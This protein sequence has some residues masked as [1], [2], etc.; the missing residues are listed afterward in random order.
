M[1]IRP[2]GGRR[3][4]LGVHGAARTAPG[5]ARSRTCPRTPL[6]TATFSKI[7]RRVQFFASARRRHRSDAR[8]DHAQHAHRRSLVSQRLRLVSSP[9]TAPRQNGLRRHSTPAFAS[10]LDRRTWVRGYAGSC[11]SYSP[12]RARQGQLHAA[13]KVTKRKLSDDR[14]PHLDPDRRR[15]HVG[16]QLPCTRT[17]PRGR[18]RAGPTRARRRR[19]ASRPRRLSRCRTTSRQ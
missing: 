9:R 17:I 3:H 16:V 6:I 15:T 7:A 19:T 10:A 14:R 12:A 13:S 4:D 2:A 8:D 18:C 1:P 11:P 5:A